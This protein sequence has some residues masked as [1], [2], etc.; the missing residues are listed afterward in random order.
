L[1]WTRL[2]FDTRHFLVHAFETICRR[3][4]INSWSIHQMFFL[5]YFHSQTAFSAADA[6]GENNRESRRVMNEW[7][8]YHLSVC[9]SEKIFVCDGSWNV[10]P[11]ESPH[12]GSRAKSISLSS[13]KR[14]RLCENARCNIILCKQMPF[15]EIYT[16]LS[17]NKLRLWEVI[18]FCTHFL[19]LIVM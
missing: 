10:A 18:T 13:A 6:R 8:Q 14:A 19:L 16:H 4:H 3:V 9:I 11:S 1:L 15:R 2:E 17:I 5:R 7:G 12:G